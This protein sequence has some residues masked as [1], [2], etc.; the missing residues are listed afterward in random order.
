MSLESHNKT[1]RF[2]DPL[3][4]WVMEHVQE[5]ETF[6]DTENKTRWDE[7]WRLWRGVWSAQDQQRL[8]EKSRAIMP[9][10]STAVESAVAELDD[11]AFGSAKWIDIQDDI[12]DVEAEDMLYASMLLREEMELNGI[13]SAARQCILLSAIYGTGIGKIA[14]E[15]S[16]ENASQILCKL[17]PVDPREFVVDPAAS[18]IDEALGV[19]HVTYRPKHVIIEKQ[20]MGV[21]LEQP[22]ESSGATTSG[23]PNPLAFAGRGWTD[24]DKVKITEWHGRVPVSMLEDI[25][26]PMTGLEIHGED[27]N[28]VEAIITIANDETIL[29]AVQNPYS[30]AF[31][32]FS[33][34]EVPNSF[35]GRGIME[36]GYWP[37]KNLDT[38]H[39][40]RT[41]ALSLSNAPMM[42]INRQAFPRGGD[43]RVRPGRNIF[44]NAEVGENNIRPL[45]FASPDPQSAR[46]I[47]DLKASIQSAT[48][49]QQDINLSDVSVRTGS[50]GVAIMAASTLKRSKRAMINLE[51][52][53]LSPLV[54]K[55]LE[56]YSDL[57]KRFKGLQDTRFKVMSTMG[58]VRQELEV[59]QMSQLLQLFPAGGISFWAMAKEIVDLTSLS[60]SA[61]I[62]EFIDMEIQ[63]AMQPP[64]PEPTYAEQAKLM[65]I[66]LQQMKLDQ[67]RELRQ[68]SLQIE[69]ARAATESERV[70]VERMRTI[71]DD[72][73]QQA[74]MASQNILDEAKAMHEVARAEAQELGSQIQE[75]MAAIQMMKALNPVNAA[76]PGE[77]V[78]E[79][80]EE[81][82]VAEN[83]FNTT[84]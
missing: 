57:D 14:V 56:R 72:I 38:E 36:K 76:A 20:Q 51:R 44:L 13:P 3:A 22:F 61:A 33:W 73:V 40:A 27:E 37:Q 49:Q 15:K 10:L 64:E 19:A 71:G 83:E 53:F 52:S 39:R 42:L 29:R 11:A 6:R 35:Y 54:K 45:Q 24:T 4:S 32:A 28:Y 60:K 30:R 5:W 16:E 46:Q 9:D 7:Y 67:D 43:F 82:A 74:R 47:Q 55:A 80:F 58:L 17:L 34:E 50:S 81:N 77:F 65:S 48:G 23:T 68:I 1:M 78:S 63:Q 66:E 12:L 21:Y 26:A 8:K 2:S 79:V 59:Q 25:D 41:D 70:D 62:K 75:Y 69:A 18:T 31:V 84:L